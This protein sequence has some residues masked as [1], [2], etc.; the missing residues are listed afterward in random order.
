MTMIMTSQSQID[1]CYQS[2][3]LERVDYEFFIVENVFPD[4]RSDIEEVSR[5]KNE[6]V[7]F[8]HI[9]NSVSVESQP[10]SDQGN[11]IYNSIAQN[12]LFCVEF[13]L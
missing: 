4:V 5:N 12:G 1:S 8:N 3:H 10:H 13:A 6:N 9:W 7:L 11:H 2:N